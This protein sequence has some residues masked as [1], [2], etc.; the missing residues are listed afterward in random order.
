VGWLVLTAAL[1]AAVTVAAVLTYRA[2]FRE[3]RTA[4]GP[5]EPARPEAVPAA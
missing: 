3:S 2:A 1:A 5:L 4:V